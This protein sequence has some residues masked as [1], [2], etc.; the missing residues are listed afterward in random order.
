MPNP[1]T[2]LTSEFPALHIYSTD[3]TERWNH[4]SVTPIS[5]TSDWTTNISVSMRNVSEEFAFEGLRADI[6]GRG[7]STRY[8]PKRPYRLRMAQAIQML[9]SPA[10]ARN[11][12]LIASHSD[13]TLLRHYGAYHLSSLLGTM[14]FSPH[15]RFIDL[16]LNGVYQGVYLMTDHMNE[17]VPGRANLLA[18]ND[19]T[20]SEFLIE[21]DGRAPTGQIYGQE[22]F[23]VDGQHFDLRFPDS[24]NVE[25]QRAFAEYARNYV[26][27]V[28]R[29]L[30]SG[31]WSDITQLIDPASFVDYYLVRE[32]YRCVD[33]G[34]T[35]V[36][37]A[38]RGQ[39]ENRR[40]F[41]GPLWDFDLSAGNAYYAGGY[42]TDGIY[43]GEVNRWFRQLLMVPEFRSLVQDRWNELSNDHFVRSMNHIAFMAV[44]YQA[45]FER[46]FEVWHI[47]GIYVWPNPP[48]LVPIDTFIGQV[49]WKLRWLEERKAWL[50]NHFNSASFL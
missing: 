28:N 2:T 23:T 19:P 44:R 22:F 1:P 24:S 43:V 33:A 31:V 17:N 12:A 8:Q 39:G 42:R 48:E 6:R 21:L 36:H 15:A 25:R 50:S 34:W 13:K 14:Y 20:I 3:Y 4:A 38:I 9:D 46:N 5:T 16:Y 27:R 41:M 40:L 32:W 7:N 26:Y 30:E 29:A 37:F 49:S 10:T 47:M 45:S 18:N 35:S 11:W